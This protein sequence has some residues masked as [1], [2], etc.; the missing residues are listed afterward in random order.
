[1][2]KRLTLALLFAALVH[3]TVADAE[4]LGTVN[5]Q[6]GYTLEIVAP[7]E[8]TLSVNFLSVVRGRLEVDNMITVR[9]SSPPV[10]VTIS[11]SA[12]RI[13]LEGDTEGGGALIR[14]VNAGT[15]QEVSVNPEARVVYDVVG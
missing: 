9:G 13:I 8:V 6:T 1:M 12:E 14:I 3:A 7:P 15:V 4:Y 2:V 11:K 5:R 10:Q